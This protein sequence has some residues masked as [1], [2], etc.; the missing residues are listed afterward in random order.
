MPC[1]LTSDSPRGGGGDTAGGRT[2][3]AMAENEK[4]RSHDGE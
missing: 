2:N 3:G 1:L 4:Y